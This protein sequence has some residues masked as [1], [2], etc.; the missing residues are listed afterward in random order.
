MWITTCFVDRKITLFYQFLHNIFFYKRSPTTNLSTTSLAL[1]ENLHFVISGYFVLSDLVITGVEYSGSRLIGRLGSRHS[2]P[3]IRFSQLT[4]VNYT[5]RYEFVSK[6]IYIYIMCYIQGMPR[7][8]VT[9]TAA[10]LVSLYRSAST[11][12]VR[13]RGRLYRTICWS[14]PV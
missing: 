9:T 8:Y 13:Y 12:G 4:D 11:G 1:G 14:S 2:V 6:T 7:R 5:I 3:F 10:G